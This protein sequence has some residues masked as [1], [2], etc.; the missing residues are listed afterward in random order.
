MLSVIIKPFMQNV[1]MLSVVALSLKQQVLRLFQ[2][3]F[4]EQK[5][6]IRLSDY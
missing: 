5:L 1:I 4:S 2:R 3:T 6:T